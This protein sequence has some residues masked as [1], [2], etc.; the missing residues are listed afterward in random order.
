M[1][2]PNEHSGNNLHLSL[3]ERSRNEKQQTYQ[4]DFKQ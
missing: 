3:L 4:S 1:V 2:N